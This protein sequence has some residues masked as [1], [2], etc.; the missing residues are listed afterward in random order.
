MLLT[1][2][3]SRIGQL[4]GSFGIPLMSYNHVQ[5]LGRNAFTKLP[6]GRHVLTDPDNPNFAE[7]MTAIEALEENLLAPG[8]HAH[9]TD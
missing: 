6:D 5:Q 9:K 3:K 7:F 4:S 1:D 2:L 8:G